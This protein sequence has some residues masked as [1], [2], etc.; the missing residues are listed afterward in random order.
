MIVFEIRAAAIC[1]DC[2]TI[3]P[4]DN[5]KTD[6]IGFNLEHYLGESISVF[7]PYVKLDTETQWGTMFES[8]KT[9]QFFPASS[10]PH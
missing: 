9:T 5:V 6:A 7:V 3:P 1:Y 10:R 4:G 2:L 8:A